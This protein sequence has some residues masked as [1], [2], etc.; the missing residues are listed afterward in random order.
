MASA[1]Y[2]LLKAALENLTTLDGQLRFMT[3]QT[4]FSDEY[5][6]RVLVHLSAQPVFGEEGDLEAQMRNKGVSVDEYAVA[7]S[8]L[9]EMSIEQAQARL[10]AIER[11]DPVLSEEALDKVREWEAIVGTI[12]RLSGEERE[13]AI[14]ILSAVSALSNRQDQIVRDLLRLKV[15][16]ESLSKSA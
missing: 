15:S 3:T 14:T 8:P 4:G 2:H 12:A 7:M 5:L 10:R 11:E 16:G 6:R 9:L 13:I 1:Y